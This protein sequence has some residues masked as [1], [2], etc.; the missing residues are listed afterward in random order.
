[1]LKLIRFDLCK[2]AEW[3]HFYNLFAAYLAEVCD[4]EEYQENIDDLHNEAL[5]RQMI[6][7]TL[8]AHNPYFV[9]RTY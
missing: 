4:E 1:M 3:E 6:E 8:Q 9:M 5:N 7:Q 2:S